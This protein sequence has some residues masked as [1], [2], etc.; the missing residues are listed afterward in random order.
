MS[1][2]SSQ[3]QVKLS[4][5][6]QVRKSIAKVLTV[7]SE[8]RI[9]SARKDFRKKRYL[10]KDLRLKKTRAFRRGLSPFERKKITVRQSKRL[11]TIKLR[12]YALAA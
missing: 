1:K 7:L 2:V 10:P 6:R 8:K 5:I 3:P 9:A 11:Q 12:K 4:K